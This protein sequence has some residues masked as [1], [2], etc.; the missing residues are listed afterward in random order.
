MCLRLLV[1]GVHQQ[2]CSTVHKSVYIMNSKVHQNVADM[3]R[4][5]AVEFE[6]NC[7]AS[8]VLIHNV[9]LSRNT[10]TVFSGGNM[11]VI[12]NCSAGNSVTISRSTV[13]F[14]NSSGTGGGMTIL[15]GASEACSSAVVSLKPTIVS[16][17]DSTVQYNTAH[18]QGGGLVISFNSSNYYC[19][20]AKVDIKNVTF[21]NNKVGTFPFLNDDQELLPTEGGN[22]YIQDI[23]GQWLNNSVRI[24]SCLIKGGVAILGGG[25]YLT[26]TIKY[27]GSLQKSTKIESLLISN[28]QFMCNRATGKDSFGASLDVDGQPGDYNITWYSMSP[29]IKLKRL[30][31][32][33]TIFDGTCADSSNIGIIGLGWYAPYLPTWYSVVFINISFQG[34]S[35]LLSTFH[36]KQLSDSSLDDDVIQYLP[37][38]HLLKVLQPGV[39][40]ISVPNA[41]FIDCEFFESTADSALYARSTNMF[42]G[43]NITFRDNIATRG[44]GLMLIDS[45]VMYLRPNTH[46]I[47]SHNHATYV[48]GAIYAQ[49][50]D[51]RGNARCFYQ[52]DGTNLN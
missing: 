28:T 48:G 49:S 34:Y 46:I 50:V 17:V 38:P 51:T 37:D 33:D 22:I 14:G 30:T 3:G 6:L 35:T 1:A 5:V 16:I 40:L 8:K 36:P 52:L 31:I 29:T 15:T 19:C 32:T 9:S 25:V 26:Q 7:F 21:V 11:Y 42:F 43:G 24:H 44:A 12:N 27:P 47:F 20:S 23:S 4:G 13:E 45:S 41:T 10:A 2:A 39:M 18:Y